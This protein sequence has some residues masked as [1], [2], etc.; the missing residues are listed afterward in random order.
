MG[1]VIE[2]LLSGY[3]VAMGW[4]LKGYLVGAVRYLVAIGRLVIEWLLSGYVVAIKGI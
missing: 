2:W 1:L 3:E 4:L